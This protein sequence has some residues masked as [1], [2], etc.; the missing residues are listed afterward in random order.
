MLGDPAAA[1]ALQ[2]EDWGVLDQLL[3]AALEEAA[4]LTTERKVQIALQRFSTAKMR[5]HTIEAAEPFL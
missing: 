2:D 5:S 4:G 3:V 1:K